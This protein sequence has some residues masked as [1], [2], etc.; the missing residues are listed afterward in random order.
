V[1]IIAIATNLPVAG[2]FLRL[3]AVAFG[4]GAAAMAFW[5]S[6]GTTAPGAPGAPAPGAPAAPPAAA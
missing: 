1:A 3:L 5:G 2:V 6:R 4:L